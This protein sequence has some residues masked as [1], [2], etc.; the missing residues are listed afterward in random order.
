MKTRYM[1][2]AHWE[3]SLKKGKGILDTQRG[4]PKR[5]KHFLF[6]PFEI[7]DSANLE[8]L[9]AA[10]HAE[11]FTMAVCAHLTRKGYDP[12]LLDT[13]ATLTMEGTSIT[14]I[15]LSLTGQVRNITE[16][17]FIEVAQEEE[18]NCT[19]SRALQV[20]VTTHAKLVA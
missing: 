13:E 18:K 12:T 11:C 16:A 8:E 1:A 7:E 14:D 3:G 20:P 4:V 19:I 15:H 10:T 2:L 17:E 9:L 6:S 5:A